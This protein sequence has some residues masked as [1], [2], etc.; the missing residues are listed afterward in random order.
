MGAVLLASAACGSDGPSHPEIRFVVP[1]GKPEA[2]T[3]TVV[4]IPSRYLPSRSEVS[5]DV[6]PSILRVT[7]AQ[8]GDSL[9]AAADSTL[10]P[11]AGS[12]DVTRD[13]IVFTPTFGFDAGLHYRAVF[14]GSKLPGA[15]EG[16]KPAPLV[17]I[18]GLPKQNLPPA[19]IV[20][21]VYPTSDVVPEN[22]LRLYIHFSGP[23]GRKGGLDY[24][25]LLDASGSEVKGAFLPLEAEFWNGD[26]TRYTLFFDPG[27]VKRGI[28]PNEQMGRPLVAG[29]EYSLVISSGWPDAQGLPLKEAFQ[30]KFR[31]G[32]ADEQPIEPSSWRIREPQ[33]GSRDPLIVTFPEPLDQ[34]LLMRALGVETAAGRPVAGEVATA[35]RETQW[36]FT[37]AAPWAQGDYR[38]V[39]LTILED[40]AGNRIGRAFEVD[41]FEQVDPRAEQEKITMPFRIE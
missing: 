37:P 41:Q 16:W 28:L 38:L 32:P 20:D 17:A 24:V 23:M 30:R 14:D 1:E 11:V 35:G 3:L 12:Y 26:R 5:S 13:A 9:S 40:L 2:A 21:R 18:V 34:G 27:R 10:P 29:R 6:W 15:G 31:A 36:G 19:T 33:A 25:R 22:Q 4:G 8:D 39:A 7:V